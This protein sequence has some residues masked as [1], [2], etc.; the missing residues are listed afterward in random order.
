[1][2]I[3]GINP[4]SHDSAACAVVDGVIVAAAEEER[5]TR[6]KH[7][8]DEMPWNA[9]RYCL[10]QVGAHLDEADYIATC[11]RGPDQLPHSVQVYG[12]SHV[13]KHRNYY[14]GKL[15]PEAYFGD[16]TLPPIVHVSHHLAHAAS[17]YRCSSFEEA[18]VLVVDG[19]GDCESTTVAHGVK[20]KIQCLTRF[21]IEQSLG[22]FYQA[23]T[24][25][26][27]L[28]GLGNEGKT[29]GLAAYGNPRFDFP[30]F[31]L[32][33]EGYLLAFPPAVEEDAFR[34]TLQFWRGYLESR[35]GKRPKRTAFPDPYS[36]VTNLRDSDRLACDIAASAQA[37]IESVLVHLAKLALRWTSSRN[38]AL[39]GGVALN[40]A[41]N[42]K[43][44]EETGANVFV[45][46]AAGDAGAAVG[47]ALELSAE[48]GMA[49]RTFHHPF[50]GPS[51]SD[52][53][54]EE[55]LKQSNIPY[56]FCANRAAKAAELIAEG[57]AVAWFQGELE[58]GP[59]ALGHRSIL[60]DPR[61][62]AMRDR[63][64]AIKNREPWRPLAPSIPKEE[65]REIL[66]SDVDSPF[67]LKAVSVPE[68]GRQRILGTVHVD[69]TARVQ[70]VEKSSDPL[71]HCLLLESQRCLGVPAVLNTSF[72]NASEPM[73]CTPTDALRTFRDS[74][75]DCLV[76]GPFIIGPKPLS[77]CNPS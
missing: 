66:G 29:M 50:L 18:A 54:I 20:G 69:A 75:L 76:L 11:W 13:Q 70:T 45:F 1:M 24:E 12:E 51:F 42:G 19:Q 46:P 34:S 9:I 10:H 33:D 74:A 7:A 61:S 57:L 15:F 43:I 35:F 23:V 17:T 31:S 72:N 8:P 73:V 40:C 36:R 64:N 49:Q 58:L 25:Y 28:G 62:A 32:H 16:I 55:I 4:G 67:M 3:I 22:Y 77:K 38:L 21:G 53:Q 39:S 2:L 60:A 26:L 65:A 14:Y 30:E 6:R 44:A 27:G 59:R 48:L 68:S 5:F 56:S 37:Q 47:A 63:I 52:D 71:F 41:A